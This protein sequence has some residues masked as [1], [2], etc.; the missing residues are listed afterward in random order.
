MEDYCN[1]DSYQHYLWEC[2]LSCHCHPS[3]GVCDGVLAGGICDNIQF[4]DRFEEDED[5][6]NDL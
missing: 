5:A 6:F 2:S 1:D 4:D 3:L